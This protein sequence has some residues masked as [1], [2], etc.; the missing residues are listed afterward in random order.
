MRQLPPIALRTTRVRLLA[1]SLEEALLARTDIGQRGTKDAR[2]N[3][4]D[5]FWF[6]GSYSEL[7]AVAAQAG[8]EFRQRFVDVP[9]KDQPA[10]YERRHELIMDIAGSALLRATNMM[11]KDIFVPPPVAVFGGY[12]P[13]EADQY[14]MPEDTFNRRRSC[15]PTLRKCRECHKPLR[16]CTCSLAA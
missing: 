15:R 12:L 13:G 4:P 7:M 3:L 1:S 11:P 10:R 14:E 9:F 5:D 6:S 16:D 2:I 8:R